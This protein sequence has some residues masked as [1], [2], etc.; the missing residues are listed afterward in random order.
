[1]KSIGAMIQQL[2]GL[3]DT[4]D[5]TEWE[6]EFVTNIVEGTINGKLTRKLTEKQIDVVQR[7]YRRHFGDAG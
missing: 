6:N 7:I 1:M 3:V 2:D 4:R 5:L